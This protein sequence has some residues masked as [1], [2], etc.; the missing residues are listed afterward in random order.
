M[1]NLNPPITLFI[2][3]VCTPQIKPET[4]DKILK[5]LY[6]LYQKS[7]IFKHENVDRL[8]IKEWKERYLAN[9]NQKIARV[10][11]ILTDKIDFRDKE[12]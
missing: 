12:A 10:V 2:L 8:K 5:E 4:V 11:A 7:Q 3:M 1:V 6:N 9:T